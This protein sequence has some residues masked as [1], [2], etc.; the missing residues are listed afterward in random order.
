[1]LSS[2]IL[3]GFKFHKLPLEPR[4][5]ILK[6]APFPMLTTRDGFGSSNTAVLRLNKETYKVAVRLLF[7][8]Y[9][10]TIGSAH[11]VPLYHWTTQHE[12]HL[13]YTGYTVP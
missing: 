9:R 3:V 10:K 11:S 8:A 7:G 5:A 12:S 1:M 6:L 13:Q 2:Y 4:E